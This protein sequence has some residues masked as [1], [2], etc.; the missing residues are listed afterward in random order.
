MNCHWKMTY[1]VHKNCITDSG[2]WE[3]RYTVDYVIKAT[4][5]VQYNLMLAQ[6]GTS[7]NNR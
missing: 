6:R 4:S 5:Q 3:E 7:L 2:P 1:N